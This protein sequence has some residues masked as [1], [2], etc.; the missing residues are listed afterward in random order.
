MKNINL[1]K[2]E[3]YRVPV[4]KFASDTFVCD[5]DSNHRMILK[6]YGDSTPCKVSGCSGT[7]R[8]V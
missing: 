7:M 2:K 4:G 8:R 1:E 6:I 3:F 5:K